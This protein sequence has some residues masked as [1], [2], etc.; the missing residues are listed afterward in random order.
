MDLY[1]TLDN[2]TKVRNLYLDVIEQLKNEE[3]TVVID[4]NRAT[5]EVSSDIWNHIL[6]I[7]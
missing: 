5:E 1:E 4:G 6:T 2:L 7:Q 3:N